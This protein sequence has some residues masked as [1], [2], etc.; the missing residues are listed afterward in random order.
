MTEKA[1]RYYDLRRQWKRVEPHLADEELNRILVRDFGKFTLGRWGRP[2]APGQ[3]PRDFESCDWD[4]GH[5]GPEPRFWRYVKHAACHWLVNFAL[6]LALLAEPRRPWRIVT[7]RKHS[8]VWDGEGLLFDFNFL[9]LGVSPPEC[10]ALA[11]SGGRVLPPGRRKRV[12]YAEHYTCE[13]RRS[14]PSESPGTTKAAQE[15]GQA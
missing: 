13:L 1:L 9:A 15:Y 7:S 2:F 3:Y 11:R 12:S 8:T 4:V 14:S 5:R 6:R 10:W